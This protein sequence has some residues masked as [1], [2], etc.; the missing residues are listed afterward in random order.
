MSDPVLPDSTPLVRSLDSLPIMPKKYFSVKAPRLFIRFLSLAGVFLVIIGIALYFTV[1]RPV[2]SLI[3]SAGQLEASAMVIPQTLKAQD[4]AATQ[5]QLEIVSSD[6]DKTQKEFSRLSWTRVLPFARNYYLDGQRIFSAAREILAAANAGING[7]APYADIIGLKG[8]ASTGDGAKTAEDRINFIINTLDKL[9]PQLSTI[10][11]HLAAARKEIDQINAKRYPKSF[12]GV[13]VRDRIITGQSLLDQASTLVND[14][15]PLLESL[16]YILGIDTPRKY[17]VLFQNDAELRA[18]G[19]FITAYA[20]L[21]VDKG[22]I[23]T[24]QSDD[25]YTLD[26]KFTKKIPAP[27]PIVKYLPKVPYWYL[28][29]QNLSPD[30]KVSMDTF[31]PNYLLTGSPKVDGIIAL[32][33]QV[34]VDLLR[35]TGPIGVPGFGNFSA[36]EDPRCNCPQ[37]F[38]ELELFADVEGPVVWDSVSGQIIVKPVNFGVRK[39]FIG[40]MMYSILANVMAQPK[41]KMGQLFNTSLSL[42]QQ[43]HILFYFLDPKIQS[44]SETF[45]LAGRIRQPAENSDYLFVVDTN[46]A[47][48]KTNAWVTYSADYK[49]D[50][51]GDG[52]PTVDLSLTYKNPQRYFQDEKTKLKLNGVFRDWLRVY[53]PKGSTLVEAKGFETGQTTGEDQGKTVFEGFFTLTPLNT[54]VITLKYKLPFKAISPYNLMIQKQGGSKEFPYLITINGRKQPELILSSDKELVINY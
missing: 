33:T 47:G 32:N 18:T 17:L 7:I 19:G 36:D 4:L 53:V 6:L 28:R 9:K 37:A 23:S 51:S 29:D 16:P 24:V 40:P 45:N 12:R 5:K 43:K 25:I 30:F 49:V 39:S 11:G 2:Q 10:G 26:N 27:E 35:I 48:A 44:A 3:A 22:K 34:L 31:H 14:A 13:P 20:I 50:I 54:K 46:F 52:T 21:A 15:Q 38:Y 41:S 42:I 1:I 8:L